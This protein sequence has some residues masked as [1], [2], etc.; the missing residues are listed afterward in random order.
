MH[1]G[2]SDVIAER[3]QLAAGMSRLVSRMV[4]L[5]LTAHAVLV[6][7]LIF[8]PQ[9]FTGGLREKATPMMISLGGAE[10][11]DSGGR[12]TISN[13]AI[14]REAEPDAKPERPTPPAEVTTA[15]GH[16]S[17]APNEPAP[18]RIERVMFVTPASCF[19]R[20]EIA[21][22]SCELG[23]TIA[24]VP[25]P[26]APFVPPELFGR[27][28]MA[29]ILVWTGPPEDGATAMAP[30]RQIGTPIVDAVQPTPYVAL[31]S[32][33]DGGAPHGRHYYW[34][35]HKFPALN[36]AVID[37]FLDRMAN[38]TSPFAQILAN[39]SS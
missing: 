31:Q 17:L 27:P 8:A 21:G 18:S 7:A 15:S 4:A 33:L 35:A 19:E 23:M 5:S 28:V 34:K 30:L 16:V 38:T 10:G 6:A 39:I 29:L 25:A 1:E 24:L 14:Q 11:P 22:C 37:V 9:F 13:R 12:N 20:G 36:D 32:M 2:V 3:A 26:P